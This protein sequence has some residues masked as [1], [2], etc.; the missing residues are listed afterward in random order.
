MI[1]LKDF[2]PINFLKKEKFTGSYKGMRF[3]M[4]K[5][6]VKEGEEA[7]LGVTVWPEPYA[8]DAT[9]DEEKETILLDFDADGIA[10]GVEWINERFES[11]AGRW[12]AAGR[13]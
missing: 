6:E 8:F 10:R 9:P 4:E 7:R 1:E 13:N 12:K 5:A 11:Q 3:R 2:M